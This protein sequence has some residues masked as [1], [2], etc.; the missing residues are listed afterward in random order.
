LG[1]RKQ[2]NDKD[3]A[4]FERDLERCDRILAEMRKILADLK[5]KPWRN[6]EGK[7]K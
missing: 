3:K 2:V 1:L 7:K 5:A 6:K 4:K